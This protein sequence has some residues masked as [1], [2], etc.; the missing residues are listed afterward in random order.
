MGERIDFAIYLDIA[1]GA[2]KA[3]VGDGC[4]GCP[5]AEIR[6]GY[7][8]SCQKLGTWYGVLARI[9]RGDEHLVKC[10]GVRNWKTCECGR[11]LFLLILDRRETCGLTRPS[12][13]RGIA[14]LPARG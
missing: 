3:V 11:H 13:A 5:E 7:L 8:L 14:A 6:Y 9:C 4:G 10:V 1:L 2:L 12:D